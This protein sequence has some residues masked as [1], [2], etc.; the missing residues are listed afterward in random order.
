MNFQRVFLLAGVA[1]LLAAQAFAEDPLPTKG[2]TCGG[3]AG[4]QCATGLYCNYVDGTKEKMS[5]CGKADVAGKC[6]AIPSECPKNIAYV[7][8][9]D[10]KTYSN[11]CEAHRQGVTAAKPGRCDVK[12]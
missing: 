7:C 2:E 12:P 6:A 8:G 10:G 5:S 9:C 11:A 1:A 4:R 3:V